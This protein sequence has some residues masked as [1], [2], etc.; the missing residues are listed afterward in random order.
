MTDVPS[1]I[2][3]VSKHVPWN[4]GK[5]VGAK[6]PLRAKHVRSSERSFRSKAG[7]VIWRCSTSPS[8]ANFAPAT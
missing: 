8:T 2:E 4:K 6:P 3:T 1:T 7:R 5:I